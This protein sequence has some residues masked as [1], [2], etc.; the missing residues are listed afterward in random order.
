MTVNLNDKSYIEKKKP[1][2]I[3]RLLCVI[4]TII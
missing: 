2:S 3:I 1:D 4:C